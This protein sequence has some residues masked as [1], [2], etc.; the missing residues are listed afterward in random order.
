MLQNKQT[1]AKRFE[2]CRSQQEQDC[3]A[4]AKTGDEIALVFV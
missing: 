1:L 2:A 4:M 3:R